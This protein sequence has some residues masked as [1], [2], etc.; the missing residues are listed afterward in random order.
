M[1]FG[2]RQHFK[3]K[4]IFFHQ[5]R[6]VAPRKYCYPTAL[7]LQTATMTP[8]YT[9]QAATTAR[10]FIR[11]NIFYTYLLLLLLY[12]DVCSS[13]FIV[14]PSL[15]ARDILNSKVCS[16]DNESL[17]SPFKDSF[18]TS[19]GRHFLCWN[20]GKASWH[21]RTTNQSNS[22]SLPDCLYPEREIMGRPYRCCC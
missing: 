6:S 2:G 12:L 15:L 9:R 5:H 16:F 19:R 8:L 3:R 18:R 20:Y 10:G 1:L 7:L 13:L 22:C 11:T 17:R 21:S 4:I 14:L